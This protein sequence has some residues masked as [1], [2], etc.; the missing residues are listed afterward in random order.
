MQI[1]ALGKISTM[2]KSEKEACNSNGLVL[3]VQ[4]EWGDH[5]SF[6][7]SLRSG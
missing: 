3:H 6:F 4:V 2:D 7:A 1:E 5:R